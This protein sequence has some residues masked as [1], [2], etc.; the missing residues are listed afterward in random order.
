MPCKAFNA[1]GVA[2]QQRVL[3]V[4]AVKTRKCDFAYFGLCLSAPG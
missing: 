3:S 4:V 1:V 2:Q